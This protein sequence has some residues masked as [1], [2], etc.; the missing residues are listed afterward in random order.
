MHPAEADTTQCLPLVDATAP[1]VR[2]LFLI[3]V[4]QV[5]NLSTTTAEVEAATK[6]D[7][8]CAAYWDLLV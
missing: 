2:A 1:W 6:V 7:I 3:V 5:A 4:F 8:G